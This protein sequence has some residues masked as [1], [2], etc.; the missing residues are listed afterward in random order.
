MGEAAEVTTDA[1]VTDVVSGCYNNFI[2]TFISTSN[3]CLVNCQQVTTGPNH[4]YL[5]PGKD[6]SHRAVVGRNHFSIVLPTLHFKCTFHFTNNVLPHLLFLVKL[7]SPHLLNQQ[8]SREVGA[9][10][11]HW[12]PSCLRQHYPRCCVLN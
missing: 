7:D 6:L 10:K 11:L 9:A 3:S 8:L 2:N 12:G 1:A 4:I 5:C